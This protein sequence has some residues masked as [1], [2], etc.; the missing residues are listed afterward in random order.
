MEHVQGIAAPIVTLQMGTTE[1][2]IAVDEPTGHVVMQVVT[3]DGT[4]ATLPMLRRHADV[5]ASVLMQISAAA[6]D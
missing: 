4:G 2:R 1:V 5:L 6:G 3:E